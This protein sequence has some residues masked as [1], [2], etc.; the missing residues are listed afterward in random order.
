MTLEQYDYAINDAFDNYLF[1]HD[2]LRASLRR[3]GRTAKARLYYKRKRHYSL[4]HDRL[5]TEYGS[6]INS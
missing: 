3:E 2:Q 1:Y 6:L 5:V 4:K